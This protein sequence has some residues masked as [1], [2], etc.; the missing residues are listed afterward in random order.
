MLLFVYG[1]LKEG[2]PNHHVN[3]GRRMPGTFRTVV[4][5]PFF[6]A[7]GVL[8]CLLPSP[9]SG[10]HVLGQLFEVGE[11]ELAA[12]DLLERVGEPG[13]YARHTIEVEPVDAAAVSAA[14]A[15]P[16]AAGGTAET[17]SR[18]VTAFVY[19]QSDSRLANGGQHIGPIAEYTPEHARSLRW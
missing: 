11:P 15:F 19:V 4:P 3:R 18:P 12:M 14:A 5:Y 1:S 13:G 8:P 7:D 10:H 6:L 16:G 17:G 9:G 2:F